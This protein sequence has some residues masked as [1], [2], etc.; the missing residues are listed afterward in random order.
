MTADKGTDAGLFNSRVF[1]FRHS[2][3]SGNPGAVEGCYSGISLPHP[4]WIPALAGMTEGEH[5]TIEESWV[6]TGAG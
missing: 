3:E 2:R 5:R 1:P 6:P 4:S